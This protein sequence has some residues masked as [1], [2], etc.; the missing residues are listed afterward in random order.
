MNIIESRN[1][2]LLIMFMATR[3]QKTT[4]YKQIFWCVLLVFLVSLWRW[5]YL[6]I[7]NVYMKYD[8]DIVQKK[9]VK[10]EAELKSFS[11]K[12]GYDKLQYIK[13]LEANNNMMPWSDHINAIMAIFKDLLDVDKSDTFNI[14]FSN[15]EISLE[16]IKLDWHVVNLSILYRWANSNTGLITRFE[17][18]DFLD[19]ISIKTYKKSEWRLWYDFTL[20]ANVINNGK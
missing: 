13:N 8:I 6:K 7:S 4:N 5:W 16:K 18:L 19:N 17:E 12:P 15:F 1:F 14:E 2:I 9:I 20:T 11:E 3:Q 10:K